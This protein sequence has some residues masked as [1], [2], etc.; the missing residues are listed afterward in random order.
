MERHGIPKDPSP[1]HWS[2]RT[3]S[4]KERGGCQEYKTRI[5][6]IHAGPF[7]RR[8]R[9]DLCHFHV[10]INVN[11]KTK[12]RNLAESLLWNHHG[13]ELREEQPHANQSLCPPFR[14]LLPIG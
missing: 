1:L 11:E 13:S 7:P 14:S 12:R 3:E 4:K 2:R 6:E 9:C 5:N 10:N 8:L